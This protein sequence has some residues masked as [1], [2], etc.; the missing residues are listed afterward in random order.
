MKK[1]CFSFLWVVVIFFGFGSHVFGATVSIEKLLGDLKKGPVIFTNNDSTYEIHEVS[2]SS[3]GSS[4]YHLAIGTG[5]IDDKSFFKANACLV[6]LPGDDETVEKNIVESTGND[7]TDEHTLSSCDCYD[8]NAKKT[9]HYDG[10]SK[11]YKEVTCHYQCCLVDKE[12]GYQ[13]GGNIDPS[14]SLEQCR[15]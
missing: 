2:T 1:S 14:A 5:W 6:L 12:Y 4:R 7:V 15:P 3:V 11:M 13:W 10:S 9:K 8:K